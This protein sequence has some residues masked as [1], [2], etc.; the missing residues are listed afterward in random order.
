[1]KR[2]FTLL[3][4]IISFSSQAQ[5]VNIP[6]ANFKNFIIDNG[7]DVNNDGEIQNSEAELVTQLHSNFNAGNTSQINDYTGISS[8][9]N[10][11][12]LLITPI[13][14]RWAGHADLSGLTFLD[15]IEMQ[16]ALVESL[17]LTGCTGLKRINFLDNGRLASL[18][19]SNCVNLETLSCVNSYNMTT[20]MLASHK[21]LVSVNL[22]LCYRLSGN[23]DFTQ[24][25]SLESIRI[26]EITELQTLNISGLKKIKQVNK[27]A[28]I[29]NLIAANCTGLIT[30]STRDMSASGIFNLLDLSGCTS[31][32]TL[33][34]NDAGLLY[35]LD[36]SAS[37]RLKNLKL[38]HNT[39]PAINIKN[40]SS[41]STFLIDNYNN[42]LNNPILVNICADD[43]EV[44]SLRNIL[45]RSPHATFTPVNISAYC[46]FFPGGKYNTIKG[47][48]RLD[49]NNDG[50]NVT[51]RGLQQV[52]IKIKDNAGNT[53][54]RYTAAGGD[55]AH[56]PYKGIFTITPF[57][58][59]P[60]FNI[61]PIASTVSFDTANS[62][63]NISNFCITPNGTYND[64]EI[65]FLPTWPPARPGFDAA[66]TLLY[67]NRGTTT[68][69]GNVQ[70]N[71][72]NSKMSFVTA[73]S[74]VISQS[75]GQLSWAYNNLQPFESKTINVTFNLLPPPINN[76]GDTINYLASITP[77][78]ND[79]TPFD[80]SFI[81]PQRVIGS[82]DPNDKQCLEGSKIDISKI[83][84]YL[85]YQIRF[86]NEGTDTA[87]SVV[88]T[89]TLSDRYDW[90]TFE[91]ISSS[92]QVDVKLNNN[93]L[94]FY[95]QHI[96]LPYK[97]INEPA[98]NGYVA[99]KI[100][101]KPTVVV[102]DSLNN[103]AAIYF[104][105]N[106]TVI[107]NKAT[108][109]VTNS[110]TPLPVKLEY[111]SISSS[112]NNNL[113]NWKASITGTVNFVI[114]K[115]EDGIHFN[116]VGNITAT[117]LRS[118][119][120]FNFTDNNPD[121]GKNYYRLKIT[122]AAGFSFY[123]KVL[124]AGSSKSGID[125]IAISNGIVYFNSAKQQNV[126]IKIIAAD[127]KLIYSNSRMITAGNV[128][129]NLPM[130]NMAGGIYTLLISTVSGEV[131]T[132]RFIK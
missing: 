62:L 69:S 86:Q 74:P 122:D 97:A 94:E 29:Q 96:N 81:L 126:Q 82:Y 80:N 117:A 8:F 113:L 19:I 63:Q 1:M 85:H 73:S 20:L 2:I 26:D 7:V 112:N 52:P 11:R 114:E 58:P 64:L 33:T 118:Q 43:F 25:D 65:S 123:S 59:Y 45:L 111:F 16:D 31:L 10:L 87:F 109:I 79:E 34:I 98:S 47:T 30:V 49:L 130:K 50:C 54:I 72:D 132:K 116:S 93:K 110:S 84:D 76:I 14:Y 105:F 15:T 108:T 119:L 125:I 48:A 38:T 39:T 102:G 22:D 66:Y 83:G 37:T 55:Y 89:D 121:P 12:K 115:S 40:G 24:C 36:L 103:T 3:F 42:G 60:Y 21:K 67:K 107:T 78:I 101:P 106:A 46:S 104:D 95:F 71:F 28:R 127:G 77:S 100:K 56:Y 128:Q 53:T 5:I 13:G 23:L 18:N 131:V 90:N 27:I 4:L 44:D 99:F 61:N 9:L 124:V 92:H 88:V 6:D 32:E 91:L 57:F 35:P 51:D 120:P 75:N 17:D 70:V 68:L 129:M 41:L